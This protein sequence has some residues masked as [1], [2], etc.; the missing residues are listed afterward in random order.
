MNTELS[1]GLP[2]DPLKPE[3][4]VLW[5]EMREKEYHLL[6]QWLE[7]FKFKYS[8]YKESSETINQCESFLSKYLNVTGPLKLP[9]EVMKLINATKKDGSILEFGLAF[10]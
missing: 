1:K 6:L 8:R 4:D 2:S 10:H 5:L 9:I 3:N 7:D